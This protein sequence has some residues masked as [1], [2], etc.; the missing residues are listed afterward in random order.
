MS[1]IVHGRRM[2]NTTRQV[3]EWIQQL[4][5]EGRATI[6]DHADSPHNRANDHALRVLLD[7]LHFEHHLT[8]SKGKKPSPLHYDDKTKELTLL[9]F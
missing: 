5:T 1:T 7:R 3:D 9:P 4:F 8:L 2:G 6:I